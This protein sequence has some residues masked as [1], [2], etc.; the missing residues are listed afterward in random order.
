MKITL[1]KWRFVDSIRVVHLLIYSC[2]SHE[3]INSIMY[4]CE[5]NNKILILTTNIGQNSLRSIIYVFF[6]CYVLMKPKEI[7]NTQC[8]IFIKNVITV[9][10]CLVIFLLFPW[11]TGIM[12]FLKYNTTNNYNLKYF[13]I[14]R[15]FKKKKMN[16]ENKR[17]YSKI[18]RNNIIIIKLRFPFFFLPFS[19][20]SS[21]FQIL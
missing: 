20:F 16:K 12:Q 13:N 1:Q 8:L 19:L 14:M 21:F 11:I 5:T 15:L 9:G 18:I 7:I 3:H 4:V 6:S 17:I 2:F 10:K